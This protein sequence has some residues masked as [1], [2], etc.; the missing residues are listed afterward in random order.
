MLRSHHLHKYLTLK[1]INLCQQ[2]KVIQ[3]ASS[4]VSKRVD[5]TPL[6]LKLNSPE[7]LSSDEQMQYI[8]LPLPQTDVNVT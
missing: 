7:H 2:V 5:K 6:N 4:S 3:Y 8:F 1:G